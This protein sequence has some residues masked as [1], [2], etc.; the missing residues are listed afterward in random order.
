MRIV[1]KGSNYSH[2]DVGSGGLV[3]STKQ[4]DDKDAEIST[5]LFNFGYTDSH[6][7]M[8]RNETDV[9]I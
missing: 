1:L 4:P 9:L 5:L 8:A 6:L 2:F 3:C 7:L